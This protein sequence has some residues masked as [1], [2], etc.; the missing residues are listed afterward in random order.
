MSPF[1]STNDG[2]PRKQRHRPFVG[3]TLLSLSGLAVELLPQADTAP[4]SGD[5]GSPERMV[6]ARPLGSVSRE[7]A[8]T[9][10][11]ARDAAVAQAR[12]ALARPRPTAA[13]WAAG[14][15]TGG[16]GWEAAKA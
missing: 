8:A 1:I 9:P 7:A 13:A 6:I 4:L 5:V 11:E 16:G 10:G 2:A 3:L 14:P 15:A 12:G